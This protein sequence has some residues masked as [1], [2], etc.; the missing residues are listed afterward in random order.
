LGQEF[1]GSTQAPHSAETGTCVVSR[2]LGSLAR[3]HRLLTNVVIKQHWTFGLRE[4]KSNARLLLYRFFSRDELLEA[5]SRAIAG[6]P[7]EA[8]ST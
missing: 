6:E 8:L 1:T 3:D 2:L 4:P 7:P 5:K